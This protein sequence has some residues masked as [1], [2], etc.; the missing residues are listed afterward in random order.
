MKP[1]YARHRQDTTAKSLSDYAV[2]CGLMIVDVGHPFDALACYGDVQ[3]AVDWKDPK[4]GS[5]T[6]NQAKLV[7][8]GFRLRFVSTPEQVEA[9][10]AEMKR[11]ASR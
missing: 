9:L 2:Q 5:L 7:A 3:K 10:V 8:R 4:D 6:P 11:E 1:S